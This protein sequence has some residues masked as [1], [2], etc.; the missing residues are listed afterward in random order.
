MNL[1]DLLKKEPISLTDQIT[2]KE[3]NKWIKKDYFIYWEI[4]GKR[5]ILNQGMILVIDNDA[6]KAFREAFQEKYK[7]K[8]PN[9]E[10]YNNEILKK[11]NNHRNKY[12][13]LERKDF[14]YK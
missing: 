7:I 5:A 6:E 8:L 10:E 1:L 2:Y 11:V 14:K 4:E 12:P 9:K 3:K 13:M